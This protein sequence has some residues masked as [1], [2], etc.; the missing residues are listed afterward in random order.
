MKKLS[1][2]SLSVV[3]PALWLLAACSSADDDP[4]VVQAGKAPD[5][6]GRLFTMLP[7]GVT[8]V[9]FENRIVET[10]ERNVFT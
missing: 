8:G 10:N 2:R 6:S 5:P 4:G 1:R 7:P 9:R 3:L